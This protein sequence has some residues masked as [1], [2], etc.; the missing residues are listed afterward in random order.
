[1]GND[2]AAP[3]LVTGIPSSL[4]GGGTIAV[5]VRSY[6]GYGSFDTGKSDSSKDGHL[7]YWFFESQQCDPGVPVED[8]LEKIGQTPLVVWLNGG[9]GASSLLGLFLENGLFRI[10]DDSSGTILYNTIS[11]NEY[12]HVIYWDQPLGTGYS[13]SDDKV[14]ATSEQELSEM[15]YKALQSFYSLHPEYRSC[16]L[17]ITGESY[18]GKYVPAIATEISQKN[19]AEDNE[20]VNLNGIAIGDGW[21]RP[22]L[23]IKVLIDY[24][25][26]TGFLDTKQ[27]D[28]M[29]TSYDAYCK[30]LDAGKMDEAC[31]AGNRI[32][33]DVLAFGGNPDVYDVRRWTDISM[34]RLKDYLNSA[35]VKKALHLPGSATW[36]CADDEGPVAKAL[37]KD[38]MA[39]CTGLFNRLLMD[40][41]KTL[42][43]TGN[44]DMACGYL[45]TENI[46]YDLKKW[47][48][49]EDNEKWKELPRKIWTST[50][51]KITDTIV[52]G[53]VKSHS[54]LTQVD[55]P[56]AGHQVPFF[57]PEICRTMLYNWLF[58]R[59]FQGY[60]PDP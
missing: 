10:Q 57:K 49:D 28:K 37:K 43:Y 55:I 20:H 8:Q 33:S 42:F 53:F 46:L 51:G 27:M 12:A 44:F 22:R 9:P 2:R 11:W 32:V 56:G 52:W 48:D 50:P 24:A 3:D 29:D 19:K 18:A 17:Y 6:A 39:D 13:Y 58:D 38:N 45:S 54:K 23:Q 35:K 60:F 16:P 34:G 30:L 31:D 1:M 7:F 4:L 41:Y 40:G 59:G 26:T 21:M 36:Q 14:Y 25:N 47:D 5:P 15:F